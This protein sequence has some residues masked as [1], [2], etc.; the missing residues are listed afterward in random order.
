MKPAPFVHHEARTVREALTLLADVAPEDGRIL[1]GGQSLVPAMA[2]R[3]ARPTHLV[4]INRIAGLDR[5]V[6]EDEAL[7]IGACVRHAAFHRPIGEG[8]L[9]PLL[10]VVVRHIAHYLIRTRGTFLWQPRQCGPRLRVVPGRG[11][12]GRGAGGREHARQTQHW[13]AMARKCKPMR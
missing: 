6:F 1:A 3:L 8:P 13:S 4:D 12:L 5:L 10:S 11:D 7:S 2:L 9:G